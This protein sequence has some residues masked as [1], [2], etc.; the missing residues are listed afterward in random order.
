MEASKSAQRPL[1]EQVKV[2]DHAQMA[3]PESE[4]EAYY[5]VENFEQRMWEEG[6][7]GDG[8]ATHDDPAPSEEKI[9]HAI[10]WRILWPPY[11]LYNDDVKHHFSGEQAWNRYKHTNYKKA[12]SV[13]SH[14]ESLRVDE[15]LLH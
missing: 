9:T 11:D 7:H 14:E 5:A 15:E 4:Q 13:L 10:A 3:T 8:E 2:I 1:A 6:S 12:N